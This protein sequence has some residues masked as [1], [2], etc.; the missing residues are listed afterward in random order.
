VSLSIY[1]SIYGST[2]LVDLGHFFSFLIL[3][4]VGRSPWT[5]HQPVA[6]PLPTHRTTQTQNK[7]TRTSMRWVGFEPTIPVFERAKTVH[8]S[9]SAANAIGHYLWVSLRNFVIQ[10]QYASVYGSNLGKPRS[11]HYVR[12][13]CHA[14]GTRAISESNSGGSGTRTALLPH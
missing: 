13:W 8:A 11:G 3:S 6:R 7:R 10:K 4:N 12:C 2:A 14:T 5:G 9:D 1:L